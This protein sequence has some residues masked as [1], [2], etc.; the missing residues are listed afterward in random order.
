MDNLRE[1]EINELC[2]ALINIKNIT[3]CKDFLD[4]LLTI[5]ELASLS[6]RVHAAN[7]L[8]KGKTYQEVIS[9]T[10]ISSATLARVNKCVKYGKGYNKVLKNE[11]H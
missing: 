11:S 5:Q 3:D 1:E 4:D 9:E 6:S 2:Q 7:L 8:L 10:K